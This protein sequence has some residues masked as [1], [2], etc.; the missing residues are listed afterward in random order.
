MTIEN[1]PNK[2][3]SESE[4]VITGSYKDLLQELLNDI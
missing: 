2:V 3:E 1:N 4:K